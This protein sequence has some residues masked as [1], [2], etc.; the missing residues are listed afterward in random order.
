MAIYRQPNHRERSKNQPASV[1][2]LEESRVRHAF[3]FF[4]VTYTVSWACWIAAVAISM[5]T[6]AAAPQTA[7]V[8]WVLLLV[9]TFTPAIIAL[10]LTAHADGKPEV[11][12]LLS[13]TLQWRVE[14]QW[15]LFA[16]LYMPAIKAVVALTHR[17]ATG[18]WPRFG[19]E[20]P[21]VIAIAIL[22]S[23]PVQSGEE[24][25]WRGYAL[26]RIADRFGL[27]T[28]SVLVG[29]IWGVWHLPLFFLPGADKYGQSF[30]LYVAGVV[31]FSVA[32]AWLYGNTNGSLLLTMLMH[33][34]FNQTIGIVSD[35]LHPGDKPFVGGA[36]L[37]FVLTIAWMWIAA[38][39]FLFR[40]PKVQVSAVR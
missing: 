15:Y 34:A 2:S 1:F 32:I 19:H 7:I 24:I 9:G 38:G 6:M 36:S 22:I 37:A 23:T 29:L 20:G 11:S 28:A 3:K 10:L 8:R 13:R 30:P 26:P 21:F 16:I 17:L 14:F 5:G 35:L 39:Y 40:M 4:S 12:A 27:S 33:S 18:A 25:G 31:A